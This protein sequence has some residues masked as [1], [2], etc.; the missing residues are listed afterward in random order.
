MGGMCARA[1][2]ARTFFTAAAVLLGCGA[3]AARPPAGPPA[4][5]GLPDLSL[6]VVVVVGMIGVTAPVPPHHESRPGRVQ[7]LA[8]L[9][10]G[11]AAFAAARSLTAPIGPPVTA[12]AAASTLVAAVAEEAFFRRLVYGWLAG[13]G[14]A[15]AVAIAAALFAVVHLPAYGVRA[16]PVDLAAGIVFGWQ[17]MATGGW[18]APALTHAA[19]NLLQLI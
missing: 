17:R 1:D 3:L 5:A 6:L 12:L 8:A 15:P 18:T 13:A 19:A 16:L 10:L 9:G 4:W 2:R 11:V 14:P 7:W